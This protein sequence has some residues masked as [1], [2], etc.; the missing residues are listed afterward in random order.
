MQIASGR[1][2]AYGLAGVVHVAAGRDMSYAVL[3]DGSLRASGGNAY[4]E[5]GDGTTTQRRMP[6]LV[7][8]GHAAHVDAGAEHDVILLA[9]GRVQTWGRGNCGQLGLGTKANRT[10]PTTVPGLPRIIV[11]VGDGRDQSF[12]L[13]DTGQVYAWGFNDNGQL[14]DGT[15]TRRLSPVLLPGLSGVVAAQGGRGMTI[16]LPSSG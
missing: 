1:E 5:V 13:T 12:A 2:H 10:R 8:A 7:T 3:A 16:F 4:G 11:E 6:V 14:G 15:V 9:D